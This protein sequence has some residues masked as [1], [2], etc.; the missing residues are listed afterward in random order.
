MTM[1]AKTGTQANRRVLSVLFAGLFL[2]LALIIFLFTSD[3]LRDRGVGGKDGKLG[4]EFT[5]L[6]ADGAVSLSDFKGKVVMLYFGFVSCSEVCPVSMK[7]MQD[8]LDGMSVDE[9]ESVQVL[10]VSVDVEN[11]SVEAVDKYVKEFRQ[12][13]IG[14]TGTTDEIVNVVDEYGAYFSQTELKD[15]D[16]SRAYRHSSRYY[17]VNKNGVLVD[18]MR[19]STTPNELRARLKQVLSTEFNS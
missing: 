9:A 3:D 7:V 17:L 11:D 14:L 13:F 12:D 2:V 18:A 19:H 10:L 6:S 1:Q 16:A 5:L 8:A 15:T 4:G